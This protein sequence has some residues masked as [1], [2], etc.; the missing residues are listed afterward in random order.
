MK[1]GMK[2]LRKSAVRS[3]PVL[4]DVAGLVFIAYGVWLLE[5]SRPG[6]WAIIVGI[7]LILAGL[8]TQT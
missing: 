7:G 4:L 6:V 5:V 2:T 3:R 1:T 8:R